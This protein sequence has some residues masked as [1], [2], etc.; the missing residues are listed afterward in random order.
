MTRLILLTLLGTLALGG[1]DSGTSTSTNDDADIDWGN[2]EY[3]PEVDAVGEWVV[4]P[5]LIAARFGH[6]L[7]GMGDDVFAIGGSMGACP[8]QAVV[9]VDGIERLVPG[10]DWQTVATLPAR[11]R[12]TA[13]AL[14]DGTILIVGGIDSDGTHL[15]RVDRFDPVT[16]LVSPGAPLTVGRSGHRT[17]IVTDDRLLVVGG[18]TDDAD[19]Y[20]TAELIDLASG[21][22]RDVSE[23]LGGVVGHVSLVE[24]RDGSV[25]LVDRDRTL[26]FDPASEAWQVTAQPPRWFEQPGAALLASGKVAVVASAESG[27]F[28]EAGPVI[29]PMAFIY[30][31][32]TDTWMRREQAPFAG[33]L[34]VGETLPDGR[35][36]LGHTTLLHVFDEELGWVGRLPGSPVAFG[37]RAITDN[38]D[39]I[40]AGGSGDP[41]CVAVGK[42][43]RLMVE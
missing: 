21:S 30:D 22:A 11:S 13:T 27:Q 28:T 5:E 35:T 15:S 23:G 19:G 38:S 4:G 6:T 20:K 41:T 39:I 37:A 25:L 8:D 33:T 9:S 31:P 34:F 12:H 43:Y 10:G 3:P 16:S 32:A 42:T 36:L 26:R 14:P 1:C 24:L 17:A 29:A 2:I 18:W 7:T 40:M